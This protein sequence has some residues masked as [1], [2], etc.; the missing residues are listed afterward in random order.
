MEEDMDME[1]DGM[2]DLEVMDTINGEE[3]EEASTETSWL[4]P[5]TTKTKL[6]CN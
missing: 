6:L 4:L 2:E 3:E 5:N 1:V